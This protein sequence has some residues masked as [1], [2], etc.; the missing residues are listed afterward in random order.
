MNDLSARTLTTLLLF[1]AGAAL[2]Q[3]T[4]PGATLVIAGQPDQAPLIRI[5]GKSYVDIESLARIVHGSVR[6]QGT[7]T[8]LT[9]PGAGVGTATQ[10]APAVKPPQLSGGYLSAQIE[11]LSQIREWR[12]TLVNAVQN[13]LPISD[14]LMSP[15]RRTADS[16]LQLAIAAATTEQDQQAA[17]LLRKEFAAM[18][19]MS[20]QFVATHTAA[21]YIP[22][23]SLDS[24]AQDQKI[25]GC[26]QALAA[27][28]ST[29]QFQD[30]AVCH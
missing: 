23:D 5:N 19:Q 4:Q 14:S 9:L 16:K 17:G 13:S 12:A 22:P 1:L 24:N 8:I 10:T 6:F 20:D 30:A 26:E 25:T 29:K 28:A 3:S 15:P 2:A 18:Q 11:A 7:Q 21:T 27:M